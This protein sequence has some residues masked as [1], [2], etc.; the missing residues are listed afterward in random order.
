MGRRVG[1]SQLLEKSINRHARMPDGRFRLSLGLSDELLEGITVL[2]VIAD[3]Q[4]I[5]EES[6]TSSQLI[7]SS[8]VCDADANI[9]FSN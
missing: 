6:Y 9:P 7:R 3:R 8:S 5:F 2:D 4:H 1:H